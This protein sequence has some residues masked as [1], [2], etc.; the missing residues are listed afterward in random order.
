MASLENACG[1]KI[2]PIY[3]LKASEGLHSR[4][5]KRNVAQ[6]CNTW[7]RARGLPNASPVVVEV[8]HKELMP[9][10]RGRLRT[11]IVD[12]KIGALHGRD[13]KVAR[14]WLRSSLRI[15]LV[16]PKMWSD[17]WSAQAAARKARVHCPSQVPRSGSV[18]PVKKSWC[19]EQRQSPDSLLQT[20]LQKAKKHLKLKG[21][22]IPD[23]KN[24]TIRFGPVNSW[25]QRWRDT[26]DRYEKYTEAFHI[27]PG[28]VA[29]PDDKHKKHAWIVAC[30]FYSLLLGTF[31]W[32]AASY[33]LSF[34]H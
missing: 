16:R 6:H 34:P 27:P 4:T 24:D 30:A 17:S 9:W 12:A 20:A 21:V 5:R 32:T 11:A 33:K 26:S 14:A 19:V 25:K 28:C 8:T 13:L 1:S 15:R 22:K 7:L 29:V 23:A 2:A 10:V 18:V 3:L 31:A